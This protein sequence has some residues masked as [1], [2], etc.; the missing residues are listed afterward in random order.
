MD[1]FVR[2]AEKR[3]HVVDGLGADPDLGRGGGD[4]RGRHRG[5]GNGGDLLLSLRRGHALRVNPSGGVDAG[6]RRRLRSGEGLR[7][8][9]G[10]VDHGGRDPDA[11]RGDELG[12]GIGLGLDQGL[13]VNLRSCLRLVVSDSN[14]GGDSL[15]LQQKS[16]RDK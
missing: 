14:G 10:P 13:G 3:A 8:S 9:G 1:C 12:G 4:N 6:L 16:I 5:E 15:G 7:E 11:S 2:F